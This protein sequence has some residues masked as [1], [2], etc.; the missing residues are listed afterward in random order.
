MSDARFREAPRTTMK[1]HCSWCKYDFTARIRK[2]TREGKHSNVSTKV[3][4]PNCHNNIKTYG[5]KE[6]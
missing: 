5:G 1:Y 3:K 6:I 4:C 2:T